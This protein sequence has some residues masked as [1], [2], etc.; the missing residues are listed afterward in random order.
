MGEMPDDVLLLII[1]KCGE[2]YVALPELEAVNAL[3]CLCRSVAEQ[4]CWVQPVVGVQVRSLVIAPRL[5]ARIAM[6]WRIMLLYQGE[7]TAAVVDVACCSAYSCARCCCCYS[8]WLPGKEEEGRVCVWA[9]LLVVENNIMR[10][11]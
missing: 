9:S 10:L 8:R 3:G 2:R 7:L 5:A 4:L 6:R 11:L 1:A